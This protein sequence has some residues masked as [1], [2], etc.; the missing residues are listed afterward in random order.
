MGGDIYVYILTEVCNCRQMIVFIAPR[1]VLRQVCSNRQNEVQ[2][3][4]QKTSSKQLQHE[5]ISR[6]PQDEFNKSI[7]TWLQEGLP[8]VPHMSTTTSFHTH[9]EKHKQNKMKATHKICVFSF[10]GLQAQA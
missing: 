6:R 7:Q 4:R 9:E 1:T 2:C 3:R 8:Y 10:R 5:T